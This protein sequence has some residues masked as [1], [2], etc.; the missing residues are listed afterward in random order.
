MVLPNKWGQG[1]LFAFSALDGINSFQDDFAGILSGDKIGIRFFLKTVREVFLVNKDNIPLEYEAVTGDYVSI[2]VPTGEYVG[3]L[4]ADAHLL[5]GKTA[6]HIRAAVSTEGLVTTSCF[7]GA[8]IQDTGDGQ[9]TAFIQNDT[10]FSF[11]YGHCVEEAVSLAKKGLIL[12]YDIEKERKI[13]F[14]AEHTLLDEN[15]YANLYA[16]CISNMK[17]QL[18]SPEGRFKR[19]WSTPDRLPHKKLW[20]WDSVFHSIG[21]RNIAPEIAEDLILALFDVQRSDGLI[22]HSSTPEQSLDRT[23]PPLIAWGAY[24]VYEKSKNKQFLKNVFEKNKSFLLWCKSNRRI[25]SDELYTWLTVNDVNCRCGESGMDNSSRFDTFSRLQS[26]DF[27]CFMAN[28]ML[29]MEKIAG[30]L[31]QENEKQFF[32]CWY[33]QIKKAINDKLWCEQ[34]KMYYDYDWDNDC[35]HNVASVASFLPLFSGVCSKRQAECLYE[36]L[37]NPDTFYTELPIPTVSKEDSTF[38]TD[39]WRG[40]VWIN[41]NYMVTEGLIAY[42]YQNFADEIV[43]KT[44]NTAN[45]WYEENGVIYEF[46]DCN[47]YKAPHV[48]NRKG[49]IVQPYDFRIKIQCIRDYGWSNTLLVDLICNR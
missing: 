15:K 27:S 33:E 21:F 26:I 32:A 40:P 6:G 48:L 18:Y 49:P 13:A 29:Y 22:P 16:K 41:Y 2:R 1:A 17:T 9:F 46:Y 5:I 43:Q 30:I 34:D 44:L 24:K 12:N 19:I 38:G 47:N 3:F 25:S 8:Q 7:E 23:Q 28:E 45:R 39:M 11:A 10:Q 31:G 4:F 37:T 20:L 36:H 35:F 14:F 42:G